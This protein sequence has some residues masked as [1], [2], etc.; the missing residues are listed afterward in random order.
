MSADMVMT[1]TVTWAERVTTAGVPAWV[2]SFMSCIGR[3]ENGGSYAW[4]YPFG[5]GDGGGRYQFEPE[6]WLQAARWA[7]INPSDHSPH[8]QDLAIEAEVAHTGKSQWA[9]DK[10]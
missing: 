6:T 2:L 5:T 4:G 8:A 1:H 7:G 10:C 3:V 9:G